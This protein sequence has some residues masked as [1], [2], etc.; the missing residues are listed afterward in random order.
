MVV[1]KK[2]LLGQ[3]GVFFYSKKQI[4]RAFYILIPF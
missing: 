3:G 4:F 2:H 1:W